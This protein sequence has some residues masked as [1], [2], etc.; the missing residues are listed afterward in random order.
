MQNVESDFFFKTKHQPITALVISLRQYSGK[1]FSVSFEEVIWRVNTWLNK[2]HSCFSCFL[3]FLL[4]KNGFVLKSW[5]W[6]LTIT[7]L[8]SNGNLKEWKS[9]DSGFFGVSLCKHKRTEQL[10]LS[11]YFPVSISNSL[12]WEWEEHLWHTKEATGGV[13][14]LYFSNAL[15]WDY[16]RAE[17]SAFLSGK[18]SPFERITHL[19]GKIALEK[20]GVKN[21][22]SH[23]Y[24]YN[25]IVFCAS[26]LAHAL[27]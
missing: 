25:N 1:W 14:F 19:R 22:H 16:I 12:I 9:W 13:R 27:M 23:Q 6:S 10:V 18:A 5:L 20:N 3:N 21:H 26:V 24:Q 15:A 7:E 2:I 4:L 17:V 11:L 8:V